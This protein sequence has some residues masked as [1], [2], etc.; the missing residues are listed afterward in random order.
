MRRISSLLI[1]ALL[2]FIAGCDDGGASKSDVKQPYGKPTKN[3]FT[4]M[5]YSGESGMNVKSVIGR[6]VGTTTVSGIEYQRY[7]VS[8]ANAENQ[9]DNVA[10]TNTELWV[11]PFPMG[12]DG[13]V[14]IAGGN[15]HDSRIAG[16][17]TPAFTID[18][19]APVGEEQPVDTTYT[20]TL[21]D[22]AGT[23]TV[24]VQGTYKIVSHDESVVTQAGT[25]NQCTHVTAAGTLTGDGLPAIV[26][27][28][29]LTGEFWFHES[30]G[31]VK[32]RI[33]ALG[34]DW[35]YEESW[36]VDDVDGEYRTIQRSG[37][38]SDAHPVW[39]LSTDQVNGEWDADKMVHAK[40][41]LEVRWA[42]DDMAKTDQPVANHPAVRI[43]FS[44]AWGIFGH[45][46]IESPAS[47][48]HPED[49][50]KGYKFYYAFVDEAAKNEPGSNGII[51][52]ITVQTTDPSVTGDIK[53]TGRI[54]YHTVKVP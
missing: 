54:Y 9:P 8:H 21:P 37:V 39:T 41:L 27:D 15:Y 31:V 14:T 34:V 32:A 1:L 30:F 42:N 10:A 7:L 40:M 48:F 28:I 38:V 47:I 46:M 4:R 12:K 33:P 49:N 35:S 52:Q 13:K 44:T 18:M 53:A 29:P 5:L 26:K 19:E 22:V 51:Y 43:E 23:Y 24:E 6:I 11:T 3:V 45:Q 2:L 20:G 16:T 17:V 25:V 36:D 50:G